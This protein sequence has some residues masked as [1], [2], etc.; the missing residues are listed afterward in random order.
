L[1]LY[2]IVVL[3]GCVVGVIELIIGKLVLE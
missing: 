3:V 2:G 1:L